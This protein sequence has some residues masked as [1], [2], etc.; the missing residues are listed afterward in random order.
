MQVNINCSVMLDLFQTA[1]PCNMTQK[2]GSSAHIKINLLQTLLGQISF[3]SLSDSLQPD[4]ILIEFCF[5][6][7]KKSLDNFVTDIFATVILATGIL[8]TYKL[9]LGLGDC[10]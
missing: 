3:E 8:A 2:V 4:Q 5:E 6:D 7:V 1:P 9:C 10:F